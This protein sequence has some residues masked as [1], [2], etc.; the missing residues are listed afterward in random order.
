[1][2]LEMACF[3]DP[4]QNESRVHALIYKLDLRRDIVTERGFEGSVGARQRRQMAKVGVP[5]I[6]NDFL[7]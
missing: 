2:Y 6:S 4:R 1:M 3:C 7:Y 5:K